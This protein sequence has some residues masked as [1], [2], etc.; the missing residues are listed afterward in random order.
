MIFGLLL[1][2]NQNLDFNIICYAVVQM[3]ENHDHILCMVLYILFQYNKLFE[4]VGLT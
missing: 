3:W 4:Q 1:L 2:V